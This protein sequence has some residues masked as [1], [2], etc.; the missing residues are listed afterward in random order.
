MLG[1][2][3]LLL[4]VTLAVGFVFAKVGR[5]FAPSGDL[6]ALAILGAVMVASAIAFKWDPRLKRAA[7]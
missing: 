4:L 1:K 7:R 2:P 6:D 3:N 5:A